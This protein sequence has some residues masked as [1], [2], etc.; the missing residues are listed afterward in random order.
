[1]PRRA[2]QGLDLRFLC[3]RQGVFDVDTE[4]ADRALD[5][6]MPEQDLYGAQVARLL[7]DYRGLVRRSEC[8]P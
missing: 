3:E 7:V 6:G 8:V 1:M 5:L 4:V 2:A